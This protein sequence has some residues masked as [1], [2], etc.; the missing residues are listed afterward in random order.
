LTPGSTT[1]GFWKRTGFFVCTYWT[2]SEVTR[3]A[4][5]AVDKRTLNL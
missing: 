2:L 1:T 5:L 3:E 4:A